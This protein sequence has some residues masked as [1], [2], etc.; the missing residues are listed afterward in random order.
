MDTSTVPSA[1]APKLRQMLFPSSKKVALEVAPSSA[2]WPL[3]T[4]YTGRKKTAMR[5]IMGTQEPP[6]VP[7]RMSRRKDSPMVAASTKSPAEEGSAQAQQAPG[8]R[9]PRLRVAAPAQSCGIWRL[10]AEIG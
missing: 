2:S 1:H 8:P 6:M 3:S 7:D 10:E 4:A 9:D 5:L